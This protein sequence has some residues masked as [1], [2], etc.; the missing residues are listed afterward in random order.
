[1]KIKLLLLLGMTAFKFVSA[2]TDSAQSNAAAN[3]DPQQDVIDY[4][5]LDRINN[6]E[7][8]VN[9]NKTDEEQFRRRDFAREERRSRHPS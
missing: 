9:Q 2:Q 6:L 7:N 5:L 1:M 4:S 8:Q 3:R